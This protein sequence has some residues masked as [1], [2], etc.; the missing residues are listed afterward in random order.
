MFEFNDIVLLDKLDHLLECVL[1]GG[2]VIGAQGL[3]Q[4]DFLE[5]LH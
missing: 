1:N 4:I 2:F 3:F 5:C